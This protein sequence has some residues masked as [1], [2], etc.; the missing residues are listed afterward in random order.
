VHDQVAGNF[1]KGV[2]DKKNPRAKR[3][4]RV[5]QTGVAQ[6]L[7]FRETEV[8]PVDERDDVQQQQERNQPVR[9]PPQRRKFEGI[10]GILH[11]DGGRWV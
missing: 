2:A 10:G 1:E 7:L 9:G 4:R 3:I 11:G 5:A 8:Y 6:E